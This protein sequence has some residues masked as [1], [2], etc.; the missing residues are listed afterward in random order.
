MRR[1]HEVMLDVR[2]LLSSIWVRVAALSFC[3][4]A[5]TIAQAQ[6]PNETCATAVELNTFPSVHTAHLRLASFDPDPVGLGFCPAGSNAW[7]AYEALEPTALRFVPL[8]ATI[9]TLSTLSGACGTLEVLGC[10]ALVFDPGAPAVVR[11]C[12]PGRHSFRVSPLTYFG[13]PP[14]LVEM[15]VERDAGPPDLDGDGLDDCVEGCPDISNPGN[16]DTDGDETPDACDNCPLDS[17]PDQADSDFDWFGDECDGCPLN[18]DKIEPGICGCA[19][20]DIHWDQ[21]DLPNCIDNC[22]RI[23]NPDQSDRDGDGAGDACD[24]C[25]DDAAKLELGVCGCG[26]ADEDRDGDGLESCIDGCPDDTDKTRPGFCGCGIAEADPDGDG[27]AFCIDNCPDTPNADQEDLDGDGR[28]DR[29]EC[30]TGGCVAGGGAALDC[31]TQ[32]VP[33][34]P[35]ARN[36]VVR[37]V[38]GAACDR[39]AAVGHCRVPVAL[40]FAGT[41]PSHPA[42]SSV[43]PGRIDVFTSDGYALSALLALSS[44]PGATAL[45]QRTVLVDPWPEGLQVCTAPF[46]LSLEVGELRLNVSTFGAGGAGIDSDRFR[47][48]C[49]EAPT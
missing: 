19:E 26:I 25:P 4:G 17:N 33:P 47:I 13:H 21:D 30:V 24:L 32:L 20:F 44:L 6:L 29:C 18:W 42:C 31:N 1:C 46:D 5:A 9:A 28:G 41:S 12:D 3:V 40:C 14:G 27:V 45:D 16:E 36:D 11:I 43:G 23:E 38:D 2:V 48:R 22:P 49:E 15:R 8:G 35:D 10:N 7:Y 37:C 39:D 34:V